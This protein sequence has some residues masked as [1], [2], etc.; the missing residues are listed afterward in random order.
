M[1]TLLR[2]RELLLAD[3]R[4]DQDPFQSSGA[5]SSREM[6]VERCS[7]SRAGRVARTTSPVARV[8]PYAACPA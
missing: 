1:Q 5:T 8:L 7:R 2:E 3:E 4:G 6:W